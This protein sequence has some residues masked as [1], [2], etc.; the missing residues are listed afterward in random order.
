MILAIYYHREDEWILHKI[1]EICMRERKSR[2]AA[3]LSM[4]EH[5]LEREKKIGQIL[6]DMELISQKQLRDALKIQ[7]IEKREEEIGQ[8]LKEKGII[9]EKDI[10]KALMLQGNLDGDKSSY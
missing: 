9:N 1:D 2:S 8:I 7:E 4:L 3:I 5:H 6:K 10:Q